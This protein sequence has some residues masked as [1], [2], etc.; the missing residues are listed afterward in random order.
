MFGARVALI[1]VALAQV[2]FSGAQQVQGCTVG[3]I[4]V[5]VF[6]TV[7]FTTSEIYNQTCNPITTIDSNFASASPCAGSWSKGSTVT[8]NS[9]NMVTAVSTPDSH[10]WTCSP[11]SDILAGSCGGLFGTH[12]QY[13]CSL[14]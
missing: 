12:V 8:C 13:C 2:E 7:D 5:G 1:V 9:S 4:G 11:I 3:Q 6:S 10:S 14:V